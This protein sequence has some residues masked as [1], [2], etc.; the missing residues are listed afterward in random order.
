MVAFATGIGC[1]HAAP[2]AEW[3]YLLVML[4]VLCPSKDAI[5]GSL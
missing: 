2:P 3:T 1:G 5:V 4:C